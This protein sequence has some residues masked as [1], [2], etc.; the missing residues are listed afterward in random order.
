[1]NNIPDPYYQYRDYMKMLD[2]DE[3]RTIRAEHKIPEML[4]MSVEDF[5]SLA[6]QAGYDDT[7]C[8]IMERVAEMMVDK[9][10]EDAKS[11]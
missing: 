7:L 10:N 11:H 6:I 9:E 3:D 8:M 4:A 1:M 2:A 5:L